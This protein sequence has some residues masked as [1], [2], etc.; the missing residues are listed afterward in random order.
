MYVLMD[1]EW[2]TNDKHYFSPSQIAAMRVD[3]QW[4]CTSKFYSRI[5]PR[6]SSFYLWDHSAYTGGSPSDFIYANGIF[7]VLTSL[8]SWLCEDDT[9]CLWT[10]E[11]K[12]ILKSSYNLILRKKVPQRIV[13][14]VDYLFPYLAE[15]QMARCNAYSLCNNY[16]EAVLGP[17]HHAENDVI[18]M[19]KALG[20]IQYPA[21]LLDG[22]PPTASPV[23]QKLQNNSTPG[24]LRPYQHDTTAGLFHKKDCPE[25]P[26]DATLVGYL[27]L[28]HLFRKKLNPCPCCM[29][30]EV[31]SANR[32][33]N[34]DTISRT[35]Y[36]FVFAEDSTVFH[37]RDCGLVLSTRSTILGT[38]YFKPCEETGRRPCKVC[39]P[40][41]GQEDKTKEKEKIVHLISDRSMTTAE[42]QAVKRQQEARAERLSRPSGEFISEQE[43]KDFFTLTQPGF[44]FFASQGYETFHRRG[45]AKLNGLSHLKGF[46]RFQDAQKAGLQPCKYCK[47]TNKHDILCA[48][49]ITSR[50]RA[51]ESVD[52]LRPLCNRHNFPCRVEND[53]FFLSTP[54]GKWKIA[55]ATK[56][57]IMYHINLVMT[58]DAEDYHCQPR[59]FLS[60]RDCF[61]YIVRHDTVI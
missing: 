20:Y 32:A 54:V 59:L 21:E 47:P 7:E 36:R 55:T 17:K 12:N 27:D 51:N 53:E 38:H 1:I 29:K 46:P 40:M 37:R 8:Q 24:A 9:I 52:D 45:C 10:M 60:L 48:V 41:P 11:A 34:L 35:H 22:P 25:I 3:E 19:K 33:R 44:A 49:P 31:R 43:R 16:G 15:R 50:I 18:A 30:A 42:R 58:P 14:L 23:T 5:R 6:D 61:Y 26:A 57:Y 28:R 39:N 4:K 56:P 2:A 13:V